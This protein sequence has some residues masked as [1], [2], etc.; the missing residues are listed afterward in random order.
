MSGRVG[1]DNRLN[2]G[3]EGG[4]AGGAAGGYAVAPILHVQALIRS[5]TDK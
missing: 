2:G 3:V 4:F 1:N 5:D